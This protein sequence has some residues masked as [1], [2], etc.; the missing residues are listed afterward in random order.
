VVRPPATR[1]EG[2]GATVHGLSAALPGE[3]PPGPQTRPPA[4]RGHRTDRPTSR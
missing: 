4:P 1:R 3:Y 2:N